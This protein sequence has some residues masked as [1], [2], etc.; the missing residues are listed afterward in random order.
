MKNSYQALAL[1][2]GGLDSVLA[3]TMI[4]RQGLDVL[5]LHFTSP[6]FG[7]PE[8]LD[9]WR[10][11]Y[12]LD[13]L[14][15]DV[16]QEYIDMM[17]SGPV[18]GFGKVLNPCINCKVLMLRRAKRLLQ[19]YGASFIVSGEVV[20]QRPMSQRRDALNS[21]RNEAGVGDVL[22]RPLCAYQL[23]PTPVEQSGLVDRSRLG[24]IRGRGRKEQIALAREYGLTDLPAP[25][26]GCRLTE[27]ESAK[28]YYDV[29]LHMPAPAPEDFELANTGRQYWNGPHW[30]CIGRNQA[31]NIA[32]ERLA[33]PDDLLFRLVDH[34]GPLGLGRHVPGVLWTEETVR[35]AAAFVASFSPRARKT[36]GEVAV[37]VTSQGRS[38]T[39]RVVPARET[40]AGWF[41]RE[42]EEVRKN[43]NNILTG[44]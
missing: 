43:K 24:N 16:G 35:D 22:L 1:F 44:R 7:H 33:R 4:A 41:V 29:F 37:N 18:Y 19:H 5:G 6:F 34:P 15:V 9:K 11:K 25:A 42:W 38:A 26:G 8:L 14:R 3:S 28:R 27:K 40:E 21:I 17:R 30:L 36:G 2:S 32:M 39:V 31:D 20:G 23:D 10:D 12:G 13:L